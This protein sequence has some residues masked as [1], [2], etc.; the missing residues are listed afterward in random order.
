MFWSP[1][2]PVR[3]IDVVGD[4]PTTNANL[5]SIAE[6]VFGVWMV[7]VFLKIRASDFGGGQE[8]YK[9]CHKQDLR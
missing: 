9:F 3:L 5:R 4:C 1:K 8:G 6:T 7:H 2:I